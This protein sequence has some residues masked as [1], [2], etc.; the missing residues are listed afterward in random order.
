M[1]IGNARVLSS[2]R[3]MENLQIQSRPSTGFLSNMS[4]DDV[5]RPQHHLR[6]E[7]ED[8]SPTTKSEIR[9]WY[10]YAIA[11]EVFAV[12]GVGELTM[13]FYF[14]SSMLNVEIGLFLPVVLE[15][16]ARENGVLFSDRSKPCIAP[17]GSSGPG[18]SR[19]LQIRDGDDKEQCVAKFLGVEVTTASFAM[20]TTSA[21][22]LTQAITLVCFSSFADHGAFN[23]F[24]FINVK[25]S[26]LM[27]SRT[28]P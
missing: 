26:S 27:D 15:Q 5:E 3:Q 24:E 7:N 20:Y 28:V 16:L 22:V 14:S 6:Y 21:A 13:A 19:T 23:P 4:F 12:V 2:T 9:G 1:Q 11:A 18:D 17:S 25:N 8:T 10:S